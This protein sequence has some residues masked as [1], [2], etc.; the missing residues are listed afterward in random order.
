M[1]QTR[2]QSSPSE[3][4]ANLVHLDQHRARRLEAH[5]QDVRSRLHTLEKTRVQ[6]ELRSG[7]LWRELSSLQRELRG[8]RERLAHCLGEREEGIE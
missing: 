1:P 5:V 6:T 2:I 4:S 7:S 3:P 8:C